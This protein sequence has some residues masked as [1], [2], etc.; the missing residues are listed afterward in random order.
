MIQHLGQSAGRGDR[1]SFL[2]CKCHQPSEAQPPKSDSDYEPHVRA[3]GRVAALPVHRRRHPANTVRV[4]ALHC[5]RRVRLL[6]RV[7]QRT[8]S[9]RRRHPVT[10]DQSSLLRQ[11]G[12]V[13]LFWNRHDQ[14]GL[15]GRRRHLALLQHSDRRH[16]QPAWVL[17]Q[18]LRR[19][20]QTKT[21]PAQHRLR[22]GENVLTRHKRRVKLHP[23]LRPDKPAIRAR[24]VVRC[25]LPLEVV[26]AARTARLTA[27]PAC[28]FL[29]RPCCRARLRAATPFARRLTA[30]AAVRRIPRVG[31]ASAVVRVGWAAEAELAAAS[32]FHVGA[33]RHV[34]APLQLGCAA[35]RTVEPSAGDCFKRATE[36]TRRASNVAL[37]AAC[38][39]W[40]DLFVATDKAHAVG[41]PGVT[42]VT[43]GLRGT[44]DAAASLRRNQG[45][46]HRLLGTTDR[47]RLAVRHATGT[48]RAGAL[49]HTVQ[50]GARGFGGDVRFALLTVGPT[51]HIA[52]AKTALLA[53]QDDTRV[54][55]S[56]VG[57]GVSAEC[58]EILAVGTLVCPDDTPSPKCT[59]KGIAWMTLRL[60][61]KGYAEDSNGHRHSVPAMKYRYCSF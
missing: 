61:R 33:L 18:R 24:S 38:A 42:H 49:L 15:T 53:R 50:S 51:R 57:A 45:R 41:G 25:A 3:S 12:M 58:L 30:E 7:R 59:L 48:E 56:A 26:G 43:L 28:V 35:R 22:T 9:S 46:V 37:D 8:C 2:H 44:H 13:P 55:C 60:R 27:V 6:R 31:G 1:A 47:N 14:C 19:R 5:V 39:S 52:R 29:R 21:H 17:P 11:K 34:H 23:Q 20:Q 40:A 36:R 4:H 10:V 54:A 16:Q 32:A